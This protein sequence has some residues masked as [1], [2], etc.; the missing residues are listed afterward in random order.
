MEA[1]NVI[2]H[3]KKSDAAQFRKVLVRVGWVF[4]HILAAS[5]HVLRL[6]VELNVLRV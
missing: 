2:K 1:T 5:L 3:S 6:R 4:S